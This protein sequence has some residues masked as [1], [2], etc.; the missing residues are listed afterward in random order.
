MA[1]ANYA[2]LKQLIERFSHRT[3]ISDVI[4]DFIGLAEDKISTELYLRSNEIRAT[5]TATADTRFVA[6]PSRFLKMRALTVNKQSDANDETEG[7]VTACLY[8]SP[9]ALNEAVVTTPG[10]PQYFTVTNQLEFE[11]P[12]DFG[13]TLEMHYHSTLQPLTSSNTTNN[14]LTNYPMLY[15]YGCLLFLSDWAKN[16]TDLVKYEQLFDKAMIKA[17]KQEKRGRHGP[18]PAMRTMG[19]TP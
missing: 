15:Y 12:F 11:R 5:I 18:V 19:A 4:D 14:V 2:D 10:R 8:K 7:A 13:Y 1:L 9:Q 16:D 17:N 6:L 3:D